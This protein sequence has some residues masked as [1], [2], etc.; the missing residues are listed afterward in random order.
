MLGRILARAHQLGMGYDGSI[1]PGTRTD[2]VL[3]YR[4]R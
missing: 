1:L 3:V 4:R 2:S